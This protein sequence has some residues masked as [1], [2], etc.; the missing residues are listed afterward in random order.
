LTQHLV[1][2]GCKRVEAPRVVEK[3]VVDAAFGVIITRAA[4]A[5][6]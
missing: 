3:S 4:C 1:G 5:K 6:S 2:D